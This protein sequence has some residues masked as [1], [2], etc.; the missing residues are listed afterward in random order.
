M[1]IDFRPHS[2]H[3]P[4]HLAKCVAASLPSV[5]LLLAV[6][7]TV[8]TAQSLAAQLA[9]AQTRFYV[10]AAASA[11]GDGISWA[12]AF[13]DLQSA[14]S[15]AHGVAGPV[16]IW[17][18]TGT[19]YPSTMGDPDSSF[20][21]SD[22][23]ILVGGFV[24][25]ES[26][27]EERDWTANRTSLSGEIGEPEA[28]DNSFHVVRVDSV[29]AAIDGF[30]IRGGRAPESGG[31]IAG[32]R[33]D[34]TL[35]RSLLTANDARDGSARGGGGGGVHLTQCTATLTDVTL[36]AN[37]SGV[38]GAGL[39]AD[40]STL[41]MR[42]VVV[43]SN[44]TTFGVG[45]GA[46]L[47][48]RDSNVAVLESS[49][50]DNHIFAGSAPA[51][52]GAIYNDNSRLVGIGVVFEGNSLRDNGSA[53][54]R[55]GALYVSSAQPTYIANAVFVGNLSK[56]DYQ[57]AT[58]AAVY[59]EGSTVHLVNATITANRVLN[60]LGEHTRGVVAGN[61]SIRNS[62]VWG[63]GS[64]PL[65]DIVSVIYST[66][67]GGYSGEFIID[68]DPVFVQ[69]A[70]IESGGWPTG[71]SPGDLRLSA[72]SPAIDAGLTSVL[73]ADT[74]DLDGDG[75][76]NEALPVDIL[77]NARVLA[78]AVDHGAYE[79]AAGVGLTAPTTLPGFT[80]RVYPAPM[81]SGEQATVEL[82]VQTPGD[83]S[84]NLYDILGRHV[85][86]VFR[87]RL[88]AGTHKVGYVPRQYAAGQYLLAAST[89]RGRVVAPLIIT[90]NN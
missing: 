17:T 86:H 77:G 83:V 22:G 28:F 60:H 8:F 50:I 38:N 1:P 78:S 35:R 10:N 23:L 90:G 64:E 25:N 47:H 43:D 24:G 52:G 61:V 31:G 48:L 36:F 69:S 33:C 44:Y 88:D 27:I 49:F 5:R 4:L 6:I 65:V 75:D 70:E 81:R 7:M 40:Q 41:I 73:P 84:I 56:A 15:A 67:E 59:A 85:A 55:G 32:Y 82:T 11:P 62:I 87:G 51:F 72:G 71:Y 20:V 57:G 14:L 76:L 9:S 34:L 3:K 42:G 26:S 12:S 46:G 45:F 13:S 19:Y 58:G 79:G 39:L 30:E 29:A 18:A 2:T 16:E 74:L 37:T 21:L 63:N 66:I 68:A 89:A 80:L 54:A 53:H